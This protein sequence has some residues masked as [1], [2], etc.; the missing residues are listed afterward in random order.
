MDQRPAAT[1]ESPPIYYRTGSYVWADFA[2]TEQLSIGVEARN[3]FDEYYT[4]TNG[5]PEA[6]RSFF[7]V[8]RTRY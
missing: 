4:L 7:A 6:G 5:F 2:L 1:T 8:V 3:L